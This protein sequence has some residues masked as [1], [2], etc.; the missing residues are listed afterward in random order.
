MAFY[1]SLD[2]SKAI[3]RRIT[4]RLLLKREN[5]RLI[6]FYNW[7]LIRNQTISGEEY[8]IEK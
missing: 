5:K 2:K 8:L 3:D 1:Y 4:E 6:G 7:I